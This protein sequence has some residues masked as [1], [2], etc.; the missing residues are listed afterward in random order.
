M[1][2]CVLNVTMMWNEMRKISI[3]KT[4]Y[5]YNRESYN[6]ECSAQQLHVIDYVNKFFCAQRNAFKK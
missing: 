2:K 1:F 6:R 5:P 4:L 3:K